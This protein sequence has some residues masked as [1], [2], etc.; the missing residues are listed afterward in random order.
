MTIEEL[1]NLRREALAKADALTE[2]KGRDY[3]HWS[4]YDLVT[5]A[6]LNMVK[7]KR[8]L[9]LAVKVTADPSC[10]EA[11]EPMEDSAVDAINY[12]SFIYGLVMQRK[13][14]TK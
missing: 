2:K 7:A 5:L 8:L 14:E 6:A 10:K 12:G 11:N 13:G 4:S 1:E 3:G 9:H